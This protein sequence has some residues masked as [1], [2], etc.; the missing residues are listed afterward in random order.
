M[1]GINVT[2]LDE[3]DALQYRWSLFEEILNQIEANIEVGTE[4]E[5]KSVSILNLPSLKRGKV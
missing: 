2:T 5:S 4:V 1:H 3:N